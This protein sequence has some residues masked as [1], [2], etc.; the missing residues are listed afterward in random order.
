M[1]TKTPPPR[2]KPKNPDDKRLISFRIAHAV[3]DPDAARA[4][5]RSPQAASPK[6]RRSPSAS[7][8]RLPGSDSKS[9]KRGVRSPPPLPPV[10]AL[11]QVLSFEVDAS[12][13][14]AAPPRRRRSMSTT[15]VTS[16]TGVSQT[17]L[18]TSASSPPGKKPLEASGRDSPRPI[19]N[20]ATQSTP[21]E[22]KENP[23]RVVE[24]RLEAERRLTEALRREITLLKEQER[25]TRR[26]A[27]AWRKEAEKLRDEAARHAASAADASQGLEREAEMAWREA[28]TW[29]E[30]EEALERRE[31]YVHESAFVD[32]PAAAPSPRS[33]P[34]SASS[35]KTRRK[36]HFAPASPG[37]GEEDDDDWAVALHRNAGKKKEEA[38]RPMSL[39]EK[40]SSPHRQPPS[41]AEA[42]RKQEARQESARRNRGR[43]ERE[44][45]ARL[46]EA[47][48]RVR[49]VRA[50]KNLSKFEREAA[51][52]KRHGEAAR[53]HAAH[54]EEVRRRATKENDKVGEAAFVGELGLRGHASD[55]KRRLEAME[56][57]IDEAR[58]RRRGLLAGHA[59]RQH[60]R[61]RAHRE[62]VGTQRVERAEL[63]AARWDKLQSRLELVEQRRA[64]RMDALGD[65]ARRR[66]QRKVAAAARVAAAAA[67]PKA[68]PPPLA[69]AA[70]AAAAADAAD[71][72]AAAKAAR[73]D[74]PPPPVAAAPKPS[75]AQQTPQGPKRRRRRRRTGSV[76][77]ETA[78]P[79]DAGPGPAAARAARVLA[80]AWAGDRPDDG[81]G[82][83]IMLFAR[84]VNAAASAANGGK[85][86]DGSKRAAVAGAANDAAA[87]ALSRYMSDESRVAKECCLP[88]CVCLAAALGDDPTRLAALEDAVLDLARDA[89]L[90]AACRRH[91]DVATAALACVAAACRAGPAP[92]FV[93]RGAGGAV[94]AALVESC[95][96]PDGAPAL[97]PSATSVAGEGL[98]ALNA[99]ART[100][101]AALGTK[102]F[103][104]QEL[105]PQLL[106]L[107]DALFETLAVAGS[108]QA[109][110]SNGLDELVKLVGHL[111]RHDQEC[112]L[113]ASP[114]RPALMGRLINLPIRYFSQP[115]AMDV[116]F[117]TLA[118]ACVGNDRVAMVAA[119]DV[120]LG[121]VADYVRARIDAPGDASAGALR[122]RLPEA[123]WAAAAEYLDRVGD[124]GSLD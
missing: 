8:A 10:T 91:H 70:E 71:A 124:A 7:P 111:A 119:E 66:D 29:V 83:G 30:R 72:A 43:L 105:R 21:Q 20:A 34:S 76:C 48:D 109:T 115:R 85:P 93:R 92:G 94:V 121:A 103:A 37:R 23:L 11:S 19:T 41:P 28:E 27:S 113:W 122:E 57:R 14:D 33:W 82:D 52:A 79:V 116:L 17:S 15:S 123:E 69:R 1:R 65:A 62:H 104:A 59:S 89:C 5:P 80:D 101:R 74:E 49:D 114:S 44:Q 64:A 47:A 73:R 86:L 120:S 54:L 50:T 77:S 22:D 118:A 51:A 56:A 88:A 87:W 39:H 3:A 84:R 36:S 24:K 55:L 40:L 18:E 26:D 35:A 117:P 6:P 63:A 108:F 68:G 98:K 4:P 31:A 32:A 13:S 42:K 46:R 61:E 16:S 112:L 60:R 106:H 25:A 67:R 78:Q 90:R 95:L 38:K 99:M 45:A 96:A 102:V 75:P 81:E 100:D 107:C 9:N 53:R 12:G 97:S 2:K 58:D 110:A